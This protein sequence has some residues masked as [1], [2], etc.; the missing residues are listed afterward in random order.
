MRLNTNAPKVGASGSGLSADDGPLSVFARRE[1]AAL[2]RITGVG[3]TAS[4]PRELLGRAYIARQL[5]CTPAEIGDSVFPGLAEGGID[6]CHFDRATRTFYVYQ[7]RPNVNHN[8]FKESLDALGKRGLPALLRSRGSASEGADVV[9]NLDPAEAE[10][11]ERCGAELD[12]VAHAVEAVVVHLVFWGNAAIADASNGLELRRDEAED[13]GRRRCAAYFQH[14]DVSFKIEYIAERRRRRPEIRENHVVAVRGLSSSPVTPDGHR[15]HVGFVKLADLCRIYEAV[16]QRFLERNV[17]S[18][19]AADNSPNRHIRNALATIAVEGTADPSVFAF[20]HNGV[21]LAVGGVT[22]ENESA[23]LASP[24]LLNGAQTVSTAVTFASD[25]RLSSV[26]GAK[27]RFERIEVLAKIV[28][29]DSG[30][31]AAEFVTEVTVANNRQN[32]VAPWNLRANDRIQCDF[33]DK[34]REEARIYYSRQESAFDNLSEAELEEAGLDTQRDLRIT[35][36]AQT[37]LASQGEIDRMSRLADVFDDPKQYADTFKPEY[38]ESDVRRIV[39]AYKVGLLLRSPLDRLRHDAP[40]WLE[41]VVRRSRN[42]TWA[43]LVQCLLNE[44]KVN[45]MLANH[46]TDLRKTRD[47]R[48]ALRSVAGTRILPIFREVLSDPMY[49]SRIEL[50]KLAF[51]RTKALFQRCMTVG[52]LRFGWQRLDL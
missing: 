4:N 50:N 51:L 12:E 9:A 27:A 47:F 22:V 31:G 17:R 23:V 14:R 19:L 24:R 6:G 29:S 25:A 40:L 20:N 34:F 30:N 18:A 52:Q 35:F 11:L 48:V 37:L 41:P 28:E 32:P 26:V 36:L 21:T 38:L 39:L 43:L 13:I 2:D 33:Q 10:F 16:G 42:V 15:L 1:I 3:G 49:R 44:T 8:V 7:F 45:I 46:G 5:Q